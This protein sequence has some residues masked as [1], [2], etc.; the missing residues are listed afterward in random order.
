MTE[1]THSMI[2][3]KVGPL[4]LHYGHLPLVGTED[5]TIFLY[6]AEPGSSSERALAQLADR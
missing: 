2:H 6:Y 4:V 5:H 3:P 1:G